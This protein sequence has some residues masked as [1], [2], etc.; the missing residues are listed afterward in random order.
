M[1]PSRDPEDGERFDLRSGKVLVI[2]GRPLR[3]DEHRLVAAMVGYLEA[4]LMIRDLEGEATTL[5]NLSQTSDLR[6]ALLA[7]VSHDLRT[8]IASIKALTTGWLEPDVEWSVGDTRDFMRSIER[9]ERA[10]QPT[11]REPARHE[12]AP[13]RRTRISRNDG[14]ASTSS[15]LPRSPASANALRTW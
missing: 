11:R 5:A 8:P 1:R 14:S 2:A 3:A 4:V 15:Y 13:S 12:P 9:R 6:A 10:P 7:A